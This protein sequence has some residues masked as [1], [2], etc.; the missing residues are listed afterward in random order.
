MAFCTNGQW[1]PSLFTGCSNLFGSTTNGF[2][3]GFGSTNGFYNGFGS[4]N[5]LNNGIGQCLLPLA[6]VT[7]GQINYS[8][9]G[10]LGPYPS[11]T[12]ATLTCQNIQMAT[13][14]T[15]STCLN[16]MWQPAILGPCGNN[17]G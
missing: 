6:S 7:N 10:M 17:F 13:G 9:G 11:G 15:K 3:N 12:T 2:N 1:Q 8:N 16:G 14:S 4:T 5:G